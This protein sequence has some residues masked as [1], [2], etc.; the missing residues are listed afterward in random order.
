MWPCLLVL[1]CQRPRY[2]GVERG[3]RSLRSA[4][5]TDAIFNGLTPAEGFYTSKNFLPLV[6]MASKPG[7]CGDACA[8]AAPLASA[9]ARALPQLYGRVVVLGAGDTAMD[10]ATSALRCGAARV[11]IAFRRG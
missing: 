1:A 8:T 10:C 11:Y 6:S 2:V 5:Q 9:S 3:C 4:R 7:M